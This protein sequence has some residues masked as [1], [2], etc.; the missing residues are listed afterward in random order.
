MSLPEM[1]IRRGRVVCPM[2]GKDGEDA[3]ASSPSLV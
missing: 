1:I 3:I 2:L